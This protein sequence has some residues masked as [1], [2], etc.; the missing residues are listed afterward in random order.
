[1]KMHKYIVNDISNDINNLKAK[2][3]KESSFKWEDL[4]S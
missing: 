3:S 4:D 2:I 1:M